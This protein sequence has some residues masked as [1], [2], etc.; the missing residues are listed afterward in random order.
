ML[1]GTSSKELIKIKATHKRN[2]KVLPDGV[3]R[4]ISASD[5]VNSPELTIRRGEFMSKIFSARANDHMPPDLARKI[6]EQAA[7][8]KPPAPPAKSND[9]GSNKK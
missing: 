4:R 8:Q 2:L 5:I 6:A 7:K 1:H 9:G 3:W